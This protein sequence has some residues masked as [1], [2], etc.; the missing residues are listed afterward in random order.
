MKPWLFWAG[1][2]FIIGGTIILKAVQKEKDTINFKSIFSD[3]V[4]EDEWNKNKEQIKK[5]FHDELFDID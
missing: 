1:I 5:K 3:K 4:S 2:S